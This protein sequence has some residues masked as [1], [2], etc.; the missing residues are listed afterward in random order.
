MPQPGLPTLV[1]QRREGSGAE[2]RRGACGPQ[3][4]GGQIRVGP[5]VPGRAA[6]VV[7]PLTL[8]GIG[9]VAGRRDRVRAAGEIPVRR[10][11]VRG[12]SGGVR[13]ATPDGRPAPIARWG[14]SR[15]AR[16]TATMPLMQILAGSTQLTRADRFAVRALGV[17]RN[18]AG[19]RRRRS[20]AGCASARPSSTRSCRTAA[21][22]SPRPRPASS[23]WG[24]AIIVPA[25]FLIIGVAR[26]AAIIDTAAHMRPRTVTSQPG[27]GARPRV[28]RRDR[29]RACP[30]AAACTSWSSAR[31]GSWSSPSCR[32]RTSPATSAAAGRSAT[33]AA[34]GSRSRRPLDRAS[35]DAERVRGWLASDDRDFVVRVYAAIVTDDKTR[36]PDAG[37]RRGRARGARRLDR[38]AAGAARPQRRA[39]RAARRADRR[40]RRAAALTGS[41]SRPLRG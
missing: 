28:R 7:A 17:E 15:A 6:V 40:G 41:R 33:T 14:H 31:S 2:H 8:D 23:A 32:R 11:T 3:W 30:A 26:I 29:P 34:A 24:F 39:P 38:G 5:A 21:R 10:R 16:G 20:S 22:R 13:C 18:P 1:P 37:V 4:Y 35:R 9:P 25:A 36:R 12:R 19:R 27:E